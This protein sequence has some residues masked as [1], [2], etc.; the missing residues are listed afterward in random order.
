MNIESNNKR[1][2]KNTAYLYI[3]MLFQLFVSLLTARIIF[4]T[5]GI[6]DYGIYGVVGGVV[7]LFSFINGSM[8]T[9]TMRFL[10]YELGNN[11]DPIKLRAVFTTALIIHFGIAILIL[12]LAETIGLWYILKELV[13]PEDRFIA[14]LWLYQFSVLTT[15]LDVVSVPYNAVVVSHEKMSAFAYISIYE[16]LA[17][18]AII[19]I[20]SFINA[21]KLVTYGFLIMILKVSI[22]IIY[23]I[24]CKRNFSETK[25]KYTF[26]AMLF[27]Q[28]LHFSLWIINGCIALM[29]YTQGLNLLLNSFFGPS[30]NAARAIAVTIQS[31]VAG[32][33]N[34]FQMAVNPQITKSYASND[35]EY[36]HNLIINSSKYSVLLL[37]FISFPIILEC[38]F[39]L[40]FWLGDT[41][42]E[43]IVFVR[44]IL[45]IG[46]I[47]ALRMPINTSVHA[48]GNIK[49]FQLYEGSILLFIIPVAYIFLRMGYPPISVF[50]TQLIVFLIA[51]Y[52]RIWIVCPLIKMKKRTYFNYVIIDSCKVVLPAMVLPLAIEYMGNFPNNLS[53]FITVSIISLLSFSLC[54]YYIGL[55]SKMRKRIKILCKEKYLSRRNANH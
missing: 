45:I 49:R 3:R 40:K 15:I 48:T 53:K 52:A 19:F 33:C 23:G 29:A 1:I 54:V 24:Y 13:Y 35:I 38:P 4:N 47:D 7:T 31:K 11:N 2:A 18:V 46:I 30:V 51:Q 43:T 8:A 36:M 16:T 37:F 50:I 14:V 27:K 12:I 42:E 5:L 10:T 28:M 39:I 34:N 41:P 22:R 55:N 26:D 32:F 25:G 20:V 9:A 21:D 6:V 44:L 17:N